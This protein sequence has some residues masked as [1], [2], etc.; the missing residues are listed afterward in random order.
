MKTAKKIYVENVELFDE[1]IKLECD[2]TRKTLSFVIEENVINS[3]LKTKQSRHYAQIMVSEGLDKALASIYEFVSEHIAG[4]PSYGNI[5]EMVVFSKN[6]YG[7]YQSENVGEIRQLSILN[8]INS[9]Y[10]R[11]D[12]WVKGNMPNEGSDIRDIQKYNDYKS[13]A[14]WIKNIAG[15]YEGNFNLFNPVDIFSNIVLR[16]WELFHDWETTY[17]LLAEI[18][19]LKEETVYPSEIKWEFIQILNEITE[20]WDE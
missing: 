7:G 11:V 18:Q 3:V 1:M 13:L 14:E 16:G 4:N 8:Y 12:S 10:T 2:A 17:S 6:L 20:E 9:L 15:L 5:K 19:S